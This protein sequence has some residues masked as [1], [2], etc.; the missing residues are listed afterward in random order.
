[1]RFINRVQEKKDSGGNPQGQA[2]DQNPQQEQ[3]QEPEVPVTSETVGAAIDAFQGDVQAQENGLSASM[4]GKGPGLRV[5][6]KD[7]RGATVRQFTGEEFL[8]LREAAGTGKAN[9]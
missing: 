3:K 9:R 4:E 7:G 6:L 1:M 8:K 2:Q 5:V